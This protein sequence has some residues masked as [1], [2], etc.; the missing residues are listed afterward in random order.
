[1]TPMGAT[2]PSLGS[3]AAAP[4]PG[5]LTVRMRATDILLADLASTLRRAYG[6]RHHGRCAARQAGMENLKSGGRLNPKRRRN[7]IASPSWLH[8]AVTRSSVRSLIASR[9]VTLG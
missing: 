2:I 7:D 9:S 5:S 8:Q 1:M 4:V 6:R 3:P